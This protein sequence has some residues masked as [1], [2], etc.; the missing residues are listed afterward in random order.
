MSNIYA[1]FLAEHAD[2]QINSIQSYLIEDQKVWLKKAAQR[3]STW[4]YYPL[5][6]FSK[7]LRLS[8][9]APVP[10][11]GGEDAIACEVKRIQTLSKLGVHVPEILAF[12]DNAILLKDAAGQGQSIQQLER[13]LSVQKDASLRLA[14]LEKAILSLEH[15]HSQK[16]YLSEA[17]A[18]NILVD[19]QHNF[20]YIDFE[21][22]PGLIH[23]L[24]DCQTRDWLC[25]IFSTAH[26]FKVQE[27][28]SVTNLFI[29]SLSKHPK[30]FADICRVGRKLT[31]L[32]NI[33]PEKFGNDGKR[34]KKCITLLKL[35]NDRIQIT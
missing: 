33:K 3:H 19:D 26:R 4:I 18:R 16:N 31:W 5:Q 12:Q 28:D 20:S 9:L 21:T 35:L 24:Q 22:D 23:S 15:I 10:N 34:L 8:M 11:K 1:K 2:T 29:Q 32:L 25:F 17:F 14:L 7:L 27:L 13:A 6:W 30:S